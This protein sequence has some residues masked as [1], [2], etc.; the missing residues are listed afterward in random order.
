MCILLLFVY[1][2][3]RLCV[4]SYTAERARCSRSLLELLTCRTAEVQQQQWIS[5]FALGADASLRRRRVVDLVVASRTHA[6]C[7]SHNKLSTQLPVLAVLPLPL[8][9]CTH[10]DNAAR[11]VRR[12]WDSCGLSSHRVQ[13]QSH[14]N[15]IQTETAD[16]IQTYRKQ[17]SST[18]FLGRQAPRRLAYR[19]RRQ[20]QQETALSTTR[21]CRRTQGH[22]THTRESRTRLLQLRR[23]R[24]GVAHHSAACATSRTRCE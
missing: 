3:P 24:S 2:I 21:I 23:L 7:T 8:P 14:R 20:C 10:A 16:S 19:H 12:R 9:S 15:R 18:R 4:C 1:I 6:C 11:H 13:P 5:G 17:N 22:R